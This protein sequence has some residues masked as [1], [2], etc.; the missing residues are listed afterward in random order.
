MTEKN[1]SLNELSELLN[2]SDDQCPIIAFDTTLS[3]LEYGNIPYSINALILALVVEGEESIGIDLNEYRIHKNSLIIL[4]P[5]NYIWFKSHT[6]YGN[7]KVKI[8]G[9]TYQF[10]ES[11]LPKPSEL[12]PLII[13]FRPEPVIQLTAEQSE[14]ISEYFK[15]LSQRLKDPKTPLSE[16]KIAPIMQSTLIQLLEFRNGDQEYPDSQKTRKEEIMT[17]FILE[18]GEHFRKNRQVNFY[19]DQLNITPKHLSSVIKSICGKTAGELIDSF[20]IMEAKILL[21]T[22]DLTIQQISQEL[23]FV[24]QSF[25]GKYF[26]HHTGSTPTL[27][28]TL[29]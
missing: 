28:R 11:I 29:P 23:N 13:H 4:Q 10:L 19:A 24:N 26:K 22:T 27:F 7:A 6:P 21:K 17:R 9:C 1:L 14:I 18:V 8:I 16:K 5:K 12:L 3:A 15:F 20:V 25:F 2:T